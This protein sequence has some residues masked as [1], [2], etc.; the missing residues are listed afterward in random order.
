MALAAENSG[1]GALSGSG[2]GGMRWATHKPI[3]AVMSDRVGMTCTYPFV[4]IATPLMEPH[5]DYRTG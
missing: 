5:P 3:V 4:I 1:I 2:E